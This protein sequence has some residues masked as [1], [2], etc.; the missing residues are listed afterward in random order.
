MVEKQLRGEGST[1][2]MMRVIKGVLMYSSKKGEKWRKVVPEAFQRKMFKGFHGTIRDGHSGRDATVQK[3]KK[4]LYWR[5]MHKQVLQWIANCDTCQRYDGGAINQPYA[6]QT[7]KVENPFERMR[8][9]LVG[10]L[11]RDEKFAWIMVVTEHATRF[12]WARALKN[13]KAETVANALLDVLQG[14]D[15]PERILTDGEAEFKN[16]LLR[17]LAGSMGAVL[18][19]ITPYH[20][21]CN[22]LT[23]GCNKTLLATISKYGDARQIRWPRFFNFA[24]RQ[25]N[26]NPQ[27]N[28]GW[29][30][31]FQMMYARDPRPITRHVRQKRLKRGYA[32]FME[33]AEVARTKA[34]AC[35]AAA[36]EE[37]AERHPADSR[38][39]IRSF[40]VGSLVLQKVIAPS[41]ARL[42]NGQARRKKLMANWTGPWIVRD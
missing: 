34:R 37:R 26:M 39:A 36:A 16:G 11:P 12:A 15:M 13:K 31:P 6:Q 20:P 35:L 8:L 18:N 40:F 7:V 38:A 4:E 29:K 23:K 33:E 19:H 28:L 5:G 1:S 10:P 32:D 25:Y 22:G 42:A 3:I 30:S 17:A 21:Q 24:V 41:P 2:P 27:A 9:D 14:T